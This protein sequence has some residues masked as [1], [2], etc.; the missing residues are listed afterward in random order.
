VRLTLEAAP[1][2]AWFLATF[3]SVTLLAAAAM[4]AHAAGPKQYPY[5]I[6]TTVGMV[7]DIARQVAGDKANVSG[8]MGEG[9]DPHL[10][11][12]SRADAVRILKADVVLYV[13]LMLEGRMG[14]TFVTAA[15]R[16][17]QVYP[18]TE[19]ID[20]SFLLEPKEFAGHW[21]PH[22]WGDVSAWAKCTEQVAISLGEYDPTNAEYYKKLDE[23]HA[24]AKKVIGSIPKEQRVLITA[25]DAFNYF[26]RAYG[27]EVRGIQGLST[28]SEAGVNDI[29]HLIDYIVQHNVRAVFVETSVSDKNVRALIEGA[30]ARGHD[31]KI[32]GSLFS[33]AMGKTGTYEGTYIGMLDHNATTIARALGG[34]APTRGMNDKLGE[35]AKS[36]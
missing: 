28:E 21:D 17:I 15:R 31:I 6:V 12:P 18:V 36:H 33:D 7:S 9:V 29:K 5:E 27:I 10:Y 4:P 1:M 34:D 30:Q 19:L 2:K 13:G 3:L 32:G 25:H 11:K 14:D 23:L 16:G 20:E 35:D 26:G 8:L 22:V 24:Y